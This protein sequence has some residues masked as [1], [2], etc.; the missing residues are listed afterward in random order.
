MLICSTSSQLVCGCAGAALANHNDFQPGSLPALTAGALPSLLAVAFCSP[1]RAFCL[2]VRG[3]RNRL[4]DLNARAA[5]PSHVCCDD[6][7][8]A[9][10]LTNTSKR[11]LTRSRV[12]LWTAVA[13]V[14][15][16]LYRS[17]V[18]S[19]TLETAEYSCTPRTAALRICNCPLARILDLRVRR[20]YANTW[21]RAQC[22]VSAQ[23]L[24][25]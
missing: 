8:A 13:T 11:P 16:R 3:S 4:E 22:R 7:Q 23:Q 6:S 1:A 19:P 17:P 12:C 14:V 9:S 18:P 2:H 20:G 5:G 21:D 24:A 25:I 10:N 15:Q